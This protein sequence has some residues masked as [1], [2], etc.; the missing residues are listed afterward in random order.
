MEYSHTVLFA[1]VKFVEYCWG[2]EVTPP[3]NNVEAR[4][5]RI[6]VRKAIY[7]FSITVEDE[8]LHHIKYANIPKEAWDTLIA[9]FTCTNEAKLQRLENE[10]RL[11][12]K[13]NMQSVISLLK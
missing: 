3:T 1:G 2:S 6:R 9:L 13:G 4:K 10:L 7:T 11:I 5:W 12:L 8:L